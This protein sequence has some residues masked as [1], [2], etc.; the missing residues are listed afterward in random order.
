M[1]YSLRIISCFLFFLISFSSFGIAADLPVPVNPKINCNQ[2]LLPANS[3]T[4]K[5]SD[6][7]ILIDH[8]SWWDRELVLRLMAADKSSIDSKG[9][10]LDRLLERYGFNTEK[11]RLRIFNRPLEADVIDRLIRIPLVRELMRRYGSQERNYKTPEFLATEIARLFSQLTTEEQKNT[12]LGSIGGGFPIWGYEAFEAAF[13]EMGMTQKQAERY[14]RQKVFNYK[15][16]WLYIVGPPTDPD[17]FQDFRNLPQ[18]VR[19]AA[20]VSQRGMQNVDKMRPYT[21]EEILG[22][23]RKTEDELLQAQKKKEEIEVQEEEEEAEP[24]PVPVSELQKQENETAK[25][26]IRELLVKVQDLKKRVSEL[27]TL[28]E[29][30]EIAVTKTIQL[31]D[32]HRSA[33][34]KYLSFF[35]QFSKSFFEREPLISLLSE[36]VVMQ[37]NLLIVGPS[38]T[39]KTAIVSK[40]FNNIIHPATRPFS[41][42]ALNQETTADDILGPHSMRKAL[43]EDVFE[44]KLEEGV[45]LSPYLLMDELDKARAKLYPVVYAPLNERALFLGNVEKKLPTEVVIATANKFVPQFF[46][47][48]SIPAQDVQ[49]FFDRFDSVFFVPGDLELVTSVEKLTY[50]ER[51]AAFEKLN[52]TDIETIR[53]LLPKV[54]IPVHVARAL[55][56]IFHHLKQATTEKENEEAAEYQKN[57]ALRA[58]GVAPYKSAKIR[59]PRTLAKHLTRHLPVVTLLNWMKKASDENSITTNTKIEATLEDIQDMLPYMITDGVVADDSIAYF[60]KHSRDNNEKAQYQNLKFESKVFYRL[61]S[62]IENAFK[63]AEENRFTA[64]SDAAI[65]TKNSLKEKAELLKN[66]FYIAEKFEKDFTLAKRNMSITAAQIATAVHKERSQK[67]YLDEIQKLISICETLSQ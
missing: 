39:S 52:T 12:A 16:R 36:L 43:N 34:K 27:S 10:V 24:A 42:I 66:A 15:V 61:Y 20:Y 26:E 59:T 33:I 14:V 18:V 49:P 13:Q 3:L 4:T 25:N 2:V 55:S 41:K 56:W 5:I 50:A 8:V 57:F 9:Y 47:D 21:E 44:R 7:S 62:K 11:K 46:T 29:A 1:F 51:D 53:S 60:I 31:E 63:A 64:I 45:L 67:Q 6:L 28:P 54:S 32:D 58:Q 17:Y 40:L 37:G 19:F 22:I 23:G 65:A 38:G 48:S 30:S 35:D